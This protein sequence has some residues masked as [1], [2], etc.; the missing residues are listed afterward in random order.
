MTL[1]EIT[2]MALDL[3]G[4]PNIQT[5]DGTER[6][7]KLCG[8]WSSAVYN[9]MLRKY[10]PHF[11]N[12]ITDIHFNVV[13]QAHQL[14]TD[15]EMI[16]TAGEG[17]EYILRE[18]NITIIGGTEESIVLEYISND[19]NKIQTAPSQFGIAL[20]YTIASSIAF[21]LTKEASIANAMESR[22]TELWRV[23][24]FSNNQERR[25]SRFAE[26]LSKTTNWTTR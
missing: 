20:S 17:V 3:L 7:V 22:S 10:R 18:D 24:N 26:N 9:D 2:N 15:Y 13:K 14:P 23:W 11:A 1:L 12:T 16:V 19:I 21:A 25:P 6:T 4:Q 8:I 5:L